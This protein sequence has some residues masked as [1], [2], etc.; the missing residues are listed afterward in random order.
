MNKRK[1]LLDKRAEHIKW[2]V[3]NRKNTPRT[4]EKLSRELFLSERTIYR[5]L[6]K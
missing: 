5:D 4:I 1:S 3:N 2:V 6:R